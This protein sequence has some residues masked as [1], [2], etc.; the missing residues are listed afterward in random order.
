[1]PSAFD[2]ATVGGLTLSNRIV[3]APMTRSRA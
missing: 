2:P 3:T 1:M